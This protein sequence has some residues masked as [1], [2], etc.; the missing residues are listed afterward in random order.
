MWF[1]YFIPQIKKII[2][3]SIGIDFYFSY[4]KQIC[5]FFRLMYIVQFCI[6]TNRVFAS[7]GPKILVF[8]HFNFNSLL[9]CDKKY[10]YKECSYI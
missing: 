1:L 8:Y 3:V 6:H 9:I 5:H 2:I 4:P 10:F 7:Q